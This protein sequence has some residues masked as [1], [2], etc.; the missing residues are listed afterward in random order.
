MC[1]E[2]QRLTRRFWEICDQYFPGWEQARDWKVVVVDEIDD[3]HH[4]EFFPLEIDIC[5]DRREIV[6]AKSAADVKPSQMDA[7]II[8]LVSYF[9]MHG[10]TTAGH[11]AEWQRLMKEA[12]D[13][14]EALGS[15]LTARLLR[16]TARDAKNILDTRAAVIRELTG[17]EIDPDQV[18]APL[19]EEE[20]RV[21]DERKELDALLS[22]EE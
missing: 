4:H 22:S 17:F 21:A 18:M 15:E 16:H 14:A 6:I 20:S 3:D 2:I 9:L 8:H 1:K 5:S 12:G 19:L 13:E 7:W 11:G 10:H